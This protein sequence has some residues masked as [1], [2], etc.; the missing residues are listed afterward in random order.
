VV[1]SYEVLFADRVR[2]AVT[3]GG[4]IVL[5]PTNA[6]SYPTEEVPAIEVAAARL[7]AREFGRTVLQ[8]APTGYSA[9]VLPDGQV[10]AQTALGAPGLLRENVPLHTGLTPY[11]QL[12]DLPFIALAVLALLAPA[13]AGTVLRRAGQRA[14]G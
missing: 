1:I 13:L 14:A 12:G 10:V 9:V 2:E 7:R 6:A 3:A 5:V 8:A 11:A 4:R